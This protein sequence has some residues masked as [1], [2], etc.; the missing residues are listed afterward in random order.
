MASV[1]TSTT[2]LGGA[3][4]SIEFVNFFYATMTF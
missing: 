3:T 2:A 4:Q 1:G